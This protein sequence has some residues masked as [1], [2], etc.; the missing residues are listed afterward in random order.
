[1]DFER[2]KM[3]MTLRRKMN[4]ML[5]PLAID[6]SGIAAANDYNWRSAA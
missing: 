6:E 1:L 5:T 4:V 3:K 2:E